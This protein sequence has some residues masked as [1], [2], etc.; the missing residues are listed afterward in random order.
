LVHSFNSRSF[1][2][3]NN[4]IRLFMNKSPNVE[5]LVIQSDDYHH[6]AD[7]S[8]NSCTDKGYS[9]LRILH[10]DYCCDGHTLQIF[11]VTP[12]LLEAL[13]IQKRTLHTVQFFCC[14]FHQCPTLQPLAECTKLER[15]GFFNCDG[16][17]EE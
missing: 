2:S 13:S 4:L 5:S 16:L 15:L 14:K 8:F 1:D 6:N 7:F 11:E 17:T 9:A 3:S 12:Q 10:L